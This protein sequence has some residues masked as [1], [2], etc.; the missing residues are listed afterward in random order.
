MLEIRH[1]GM[2]DTIATQHSYNQLYQSKGIQNLDSFYLWLINLLKA[3]P[4]KRILDISCGE[5]RLVILA[6][7]MGFTA[8]G[9]DFAL[10]ALKAAQEQDKQSCWMAGDGEILPIRSE[11]CDYITHIGSLEHYQNPMAGIREIA[12]VLKHGGTAC[13]L[14]PNSYGLL[15]NIKNVFETGDIFDDGQ[16]LQR[17]NTL[18]GWQLMLE[19]C[20]LVPYKILKYERAWPRTLSDVGWYLFHPLKIFRL[21]FS[22][23]IPLNLGNCIVYLCKREI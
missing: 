14:L 6:R 10:A 7:R 9:V 20:K 13:I 22:V 4:K 2:D 1:A 5:G 16:P 18:K 19:S 11:S 17:Y 23:L 15:G 8:I 21:F 12:R 3:E